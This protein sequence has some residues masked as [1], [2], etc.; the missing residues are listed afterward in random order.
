MAITL[1]ATSGASNANSYCTVV[2]A[3]A[4]NEAHISGA[5]WAAANTTQKEQAL[6]SAT[7]LLDSYLS[8]QGTVAT[9]TQ[10]LQ[11]PRESMMWMPGCSVCATN[12]AYID[13]TV[14]P[15][16]LKNATSEYG[17]LLLGGDPTAPSSTEQADLSSLR[18]ADIELKFNKPVDAAMSASKTVVP[19]SVKAYLD[20]WIWSTAGVVP[21]V[22]V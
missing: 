14:I 6:I 21:L 3:D 4:Y 8:W 16:Q 11:W 9:P 1:V 7:R 17:R 13:P 20:Q 12:S 15:V 22:R 10:A 19:G 5:S 2:E 18:A